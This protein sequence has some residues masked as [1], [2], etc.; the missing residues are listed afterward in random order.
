MKA[1]KSITHLVGNQRS[2][3]PPLIPP[4]LRAKKDRQG[5]CLEN[6]TNLSISWPQ[7]GS[8]LRQISKQYH[9][10]L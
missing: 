10:D 3:D 1:G 9:R 8:F 2:F 5:A 7:I 4:Y 6:Q